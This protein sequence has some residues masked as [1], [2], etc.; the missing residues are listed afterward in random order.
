MEVTS[1]MV[2]ERLIEAS[3]SHYRGPNRND[4]DGMSTS[5]DPDWTTNTC[6]DR[7]RGGGWLTIT[8]RNRVILFHT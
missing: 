2:T 6:R 5:G 1:I 3:N 8:P 4:S 7:Q